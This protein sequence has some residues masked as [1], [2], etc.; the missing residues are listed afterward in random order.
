MSKNSE[1]FELRAL[2]VQQAAKACGI[3]RSTIFRLMKDR[4]L[5]SIRIGARRLI[6]VEALDSLLGGGAS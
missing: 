6:R 3:S 5:E 1:T 4:K 2:S